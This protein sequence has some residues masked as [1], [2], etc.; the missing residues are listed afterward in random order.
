MICQLKEYR[1]LKGMTQIEIAQKAGVTRQTIIS[2]ERGKY[3]PSLILAMK[4]A[5]LLNCTMEQLFKLE[6]KDWSSE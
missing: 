2:L 6:N 3:K 4:L 1:K 5:F